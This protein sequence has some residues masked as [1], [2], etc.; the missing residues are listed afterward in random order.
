MYNSKKRFKYN[1]IKRY[2]EYKNLHFFLKN[3]YFGKAQVFS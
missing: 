3:H 2:Q 1:F